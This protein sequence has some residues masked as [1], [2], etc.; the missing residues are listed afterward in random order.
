MAD[1]EQLEAERFDAGEHA[2]EGGLVDVVAD[3]HGV[4]ARGGGAQ[5]VEGLEQGV[6]PGGRGP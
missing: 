1:V 2:E 3:Q 5:A 6:A 4:R